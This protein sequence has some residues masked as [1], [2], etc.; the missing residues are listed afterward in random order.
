MNSG[1]HRHTHTQFQ[2][3][4]LNN[5]KK[6]PINHMLQRKPSDLFCSAKNYFRY[7]NKE[8]ILLENT[9]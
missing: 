5:Y 9:V 2:F 6:P 1:T 7:K 8:T 4:I 3:K